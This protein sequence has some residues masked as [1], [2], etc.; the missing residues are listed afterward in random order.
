LRFIV[1]QQVSAVGY[2]SGFSEHFGWFG[3]VSLAVLGNNRSVRFRHA[4]ALV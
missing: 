3:L 2:C 4:A 1:A